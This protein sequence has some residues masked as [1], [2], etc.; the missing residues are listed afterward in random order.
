M[1]GVTGSTPS[2]TVVST[3]P[4]DGE[5][6]ESFSTIEVDFSDQ[7]LLTSVKASD[8][9]VDG[10]PAD[11]VAIGIHRVMR[12]DPPDVVI[13]GANLGQ[14]L[15]SNVMLSGTVGA[16]AMA[17]EQHR[18]CSARFPNSQISKSFQPQLDTS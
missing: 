9:T 16:A 3:L 6:V 14:N 8:L 15:G 4:S 5:T 13:S 2:L 17:A 10:S 1:S 7:L 18:P 11:A 12:D